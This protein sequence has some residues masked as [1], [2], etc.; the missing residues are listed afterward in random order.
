MAF[1][2]GLFVGV[3]LGVF[4][5]CLIISGRTESWVK[6]TNERMRKEI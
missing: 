2:A 1:I 3:L 5:I 4:G 6:K